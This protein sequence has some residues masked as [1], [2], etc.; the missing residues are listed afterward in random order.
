[1]FESPV[2]VAAALRRY[3]EMFDPRSGSVI[4]LG[5]KR[6]DPSGGPFRSDFLRSVDERAELSRRMLGRLKP[7]E[8]LLLVL[9]YVADMQVSRIARQLEVSRVHCYRL[10]DKALKALCD[11]PP[12]EKSSSAR[13]NR[14]GA[15]P[16]V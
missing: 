8:R 16:G 13:S 3:A 12:A 15:S 14:P 11:P 9:W 1:V 10:R 6:P 4:A 7:R 5:G 2:A